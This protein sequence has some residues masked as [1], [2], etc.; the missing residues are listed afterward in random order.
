MM[1]LRRPER[2]LMLQLEAWTGWRRIVAQFEDAGYGLIGHFSRLASE[3]CD[4]RFTAE[5]FQTEQCEQGEK[6]VNQLFGERL[7]T[8]QGKFR[9][10][11]Q[12]VAARLQE[13]DR[14]ARFERPLY[15]FREAEMSIPDDGIEI[16]KQKDAQR[17]LDLVAPEL[18][19]TVRKRLGGRTVCKTYGGWLR[20]I[21]AVSTDRIQRF[22]LSVV[23]LA[24]RIEL[25]DTTPV[26]TE[27]V[28]P[29]EV[30][31]ALLFYQLVPP[32]RN[33]REP[34][35]QTP[36]S[37]AISNMA[38]HGVRAQLHFFDLLMNDLAENSRARRN[39]EAPWRAR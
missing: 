25:I 8:I 31:E 20:G 32:P 34:P 28:A 30:A 9:A 21:A 16:A 37:R 36:D 23:D 2:E 27:V 4:G 38:K 10:Q 26:I 5:A 13:A 22:S 14:L 29:G 6:Y 35:P 11:L 7:P 39:E 24:L 1:A 18:G 15:F 17:Y 33:L 12:Q 3:L 19:F